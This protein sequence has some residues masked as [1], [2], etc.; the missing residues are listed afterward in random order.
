VTATVN[1]A[2]TYGYEKQLYT[3]R[4]FFYQQAGWV[5]IWEELV[6]DVYGG[7][8]IYAS[9]TGTVTAKAYISGGVTLG[10]EYERGV[11]WTGFTDKNFN[12][13]GDVTWTIN[14]E[15]TLTPY[16]SVRPTVYIYSVVGPKFDIRPYVELKGEHSQSGDTVYDSW[17]LSG[18][19][20]ADLNFDLRGYGEILDKSINL[21]DFRTVVAGKST[22]TFTGTT[23]GTATYL[24]FQVDSGV[25]SI[26]ITY[27]GQSVERVCVDNP[28]HQTEIFWTYGNPIP[29]TYTVDATHWPPLK[30]GQWCVRVMDTVSGGHTYTVTVTVN[31]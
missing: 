27:N 14:G 24:Y 10:G 11:G 4:H 29:V 8:D 28:D 16:I 2:G 25:K 22:Y 9:A 26:T 23:K 5:P 6:V 3:Y 15:V 13:Y 17:T 12:A 18:G 7:F 31:Y 19:V 20:K 21:F 30:A 1:T